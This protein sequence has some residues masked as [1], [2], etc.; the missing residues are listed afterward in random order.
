MKKK[1]KDLTYGEIVEICK[2]REDCENCPFLR[3]GLYCAAKYYP[4]EIPEGALNKEVD[5]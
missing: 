5:V 1:L 3:L 2:K 4:R